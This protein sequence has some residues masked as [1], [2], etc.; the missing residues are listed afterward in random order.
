LFILNVEIKMEEN[1]PKRYRRKKADLEADIIKSAESLIKKKGFSAMLVTD[2]IKKARIEPPV[3][4]NRYNN[5]SEFFDDFVKRYDYWFKDLL[6]SNT[7]S[8]VSADGY[9]AILQNLHRALGD[10]SVMLEL[11]RWEVAEG[12]DTTERTSMLREFHTMPLV[13][14]YEREFGDT[15]VDINAISALIIGGIYYLNLHRDRSPFGQ[16]DLNTP[17]GKERVDKALGT[18]AQMLFEKKEEHDYKASIA[19]RLRSRG[20]SEEIIGECL[21]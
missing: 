9:V 4:Y 12:N 15:G 7:V 18:L 1:K 5:L 16:I 11:L 21:A 17:E 14:S 13:R 6:D 8:E 3:F 10:R 19:D 20:V 2:L